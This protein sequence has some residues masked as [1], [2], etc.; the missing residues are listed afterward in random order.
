[1]VMGPLEFM[2]IHNH[3]G[4]VSV[5]ETRGIKDHLFSRGEDRS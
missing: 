5:E 3:T 1:M 2:I 4:T